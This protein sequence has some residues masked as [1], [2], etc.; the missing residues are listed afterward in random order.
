MKDAYIRQEITWVTK[1]I[2]IDVETGEIISNDEMKENYIIIKKKK[3]I[4]VYKKTGTI[5]FTNECR[6]NE[7]KQGSLF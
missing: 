3:K 2:N 1:N 4:Y 7:Y 5:T 6:R